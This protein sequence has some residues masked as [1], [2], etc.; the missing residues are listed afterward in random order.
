MENDP[1]VV[2]KLSRR[3]FLLGAGAVASGAVMAGMVG[4][5]PNPTASNSGGAGGANG[6]AAIDEHIAPGMRA[7]AKLENAEPIPPEDPPAKWTAEADLVVVG[8]G[9]GG[10][11]AALLAREQGASVIVVEKNGT[12]GGASQ[13]SMSLM[14]MAGTAADQVAVGYGFPEAPYDRGNF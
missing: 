10:L 13:H 1:N 11:A 5:Q 9:G 2:T 6:V 4:C 3:S 8:T 14:N 7:T 12:P